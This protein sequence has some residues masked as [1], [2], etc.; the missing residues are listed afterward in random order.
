ML[1]KGTVFSFLLVFLLIFSFDLSAQEKVLV[2]SDSSYVLIQNNTLT[3]ADNDY[4]TELPFAILFPVFSK[5][6]IH[7][8]NLSQINLI[9]K[10]KNPAG[11]KQILLNN[12]VISFSEEGLFFKVLDITPGKN[13]L[14]FKFI[15]SKGRTLRVNFFIVRSEDQ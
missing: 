4:S 2:S 12:E 5:K 13:I 10:V 3:V 14:R 9:G 6:R 1:K 15:P 11:T 7:N 8:T